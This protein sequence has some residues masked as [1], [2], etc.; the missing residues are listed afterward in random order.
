MSNLIV[1]SY[2]E[3]TRYLFCALKAKSVARGQN[4]RGPYMK[5]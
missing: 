4:G 2:K 3:G 5:V 1:K